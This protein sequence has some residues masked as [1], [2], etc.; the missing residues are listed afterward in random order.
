MYNVKNCL[1]PPT[2]FSGK[3]DRV[4]PNDV[5][6]KRLTEK[7]RKRK[8]VYILWLIGNLQNLHN[9]S[10]A[11]QTQNIMLFYYVRNWFTLSDLEQIR[12]HNTKLINSLTP[13]SLTEPI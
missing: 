5:K 6:I 11:K 13:N 2:S 10:K 7:L 9:D 12:V 3:D 1:E 4:M 8:L